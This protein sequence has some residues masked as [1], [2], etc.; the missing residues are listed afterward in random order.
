LASDLDLERTPDEARG[1]GR[2]QK[3][4]AFL[5]IDIGG[6]KTAFAVVTRRGRI[7]HQVSITTPRGSAKRAVGQILDTAAQASRQ[8]R[9]AGLGIAVPAVVEAGVLRWT[10]EA[11]RGWSGLA[12]GA[13]AEHAL[14]ARCAVEFD[15]YAAALGERWL[16][17]THGFHDSLVMIVGTGIGAGYIHRGRLVRG[18]SGVAGA[19][20]WLRSVGRD[21]MSRPLEE[22]ASGTAILRNATG[23]LPLGATPYADTASVFVAA[24]MGDPIATRTIEEAISALGDAVGGL[25]SILAPQ[26]VVL[27]GGVGSRP[28][29]V[30]RVREVARRTAQPHSAAAVLIEPSSLGGQSSLIG[31]AYLA[32]ETMGRRPPDE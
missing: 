3:L 4:Q 23:R 9:L 21:G 30:H 31:A 27:G 11:L 6:T 10:P 25:V 5:A 15:G 2:M 7:L 17:R 13:M 1:K 32:T 28:D 26:I 18:S 12:L 29:L 22:V 8:F 16:G 20:G 19:V 14:G 24:D